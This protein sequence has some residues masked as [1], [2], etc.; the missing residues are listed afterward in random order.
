MKKLPRDLISIR[1]VA[2]FIDYMLVGIKNEERN[3][4]LVE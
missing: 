4:K 3:D 2:S 1:Q